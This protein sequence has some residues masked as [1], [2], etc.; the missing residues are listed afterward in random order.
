MT[1]VGKYS[2]LPLSLTMYD[3]MV[4]TKMEIIMGAR[5]RSTLLSIARYVSGTT[6]RSG[7]I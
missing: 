4:H 2:M 5:P 1:K 6:L 7:T 3:P